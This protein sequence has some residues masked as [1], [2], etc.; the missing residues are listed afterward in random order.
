MSED[1]AVLSRL[2]PPNIRNVNRCV[3]LWNTG[4]YMR[5]YFEEG[6]INIQKE[7]YNSFVGLLMIK[8]EMII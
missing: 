1:I 8:N 5:A 4:V 2:A 6:E 3:K 7:L